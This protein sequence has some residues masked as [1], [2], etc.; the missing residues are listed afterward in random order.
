MGQIEN[1]DFGLST[2]VCWSEVLEIRSR[3]LDHDLR[4][5]KET[6]QNNKE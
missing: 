4:M 6:K 1:S 3:G 5:T 2:V